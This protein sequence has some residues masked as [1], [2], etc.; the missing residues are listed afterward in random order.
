MELLNCD[1]KV[2]PTNVTLTLTTAGVV[3]SSNPL[4]MEYNNGTFFILAWAKVTT[5]TNITSMLAKIVR[6]TTT[7]GTL[8]NE[9]NIQT[10][11]AAAGSNEFFMAAGV[12]VRVNE[13]TAQY[14]L[15]LAQA[16]A[17]GNGT[18]LESGIVVMQM[19]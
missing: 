3:I 12:D 18:V 9:S 16:G 15:T 14:S 4:P 13:A 1:A 6:G 10:I 2:D 7:A 17:D 8:V 5:G 11:A 19:N